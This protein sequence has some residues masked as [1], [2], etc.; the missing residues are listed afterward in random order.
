M[1]PL[2][3]HFRQPAL[4]IKLPSLGRYWEEGSI[5]LPVSNEIP[6]YPMTAK[7]EIII[8]TP[9]ALLNGESVVQVIQNCCPNIKDAWK[10][11][12]VDVDAVLIAIRI[13][14]YGNE[15]PINTNC[16]HCGHTSRH[17]IELSPILDR[18]QCPDYNKFLNVN[19]LKIKIKPQNYFE[20]NRRNLVLFEEDRIIK[21]INDENLPDDQKVK[22]FNDHLNRLVDLNLEIVATSI[23]F[24]ELPDGTKVS[25]QRY[26]REFFEN[27]ENAI[28]KKMLTELENINK[29]AALPKLNLQCEECNKDYTSN[30]EFDYANFFAVAY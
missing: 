25:D 2:S 10:M 18:I 11:P 22:Q 21:T 13:A 19:D 9:D 20:N 3:K 16:P 15:M 5:E 8:R 17:E 6:V 24:I 30:L 23:D 27:C 4:Y 12:S 7:D 29:A 1:N 14:S 28:F 26:I